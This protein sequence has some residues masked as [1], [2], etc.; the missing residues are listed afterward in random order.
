MV[1][2]G[3]SDAYYLSEYKARIRVGGHLLLSNNSSDLPN[4]RDALTVAQIIKAV[5]S[6]AVEAKLGALYIN[7]RE[8][9]PTYHTLFAM[10]HP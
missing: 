6:S 4:N 2:A 8:A 3:H 7:F 1:L 5:M 9:I 10:G